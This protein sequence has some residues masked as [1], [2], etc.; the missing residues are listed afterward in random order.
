MVKRASPGVVLGSVEGRPHTNPDS[1]LPPSGPVHPPPSTHD[2]PV[3]ERPRPPSER[4]RRLHLLEHGEDP[5]EER[6]LL[7]PWEQQ[8]EVY[9]HDGGGGQRADRHPRGVQRAAFG[10]FGSRGGQQIAMGGREEEGGLA[11]ARD[12]LGLSERGA[13]V[14]HE[15]GEE[16]LLE[17][18]ELLPLVGRR[19]SGAPQ[20][21]GGRAGG[22][23]PWDPASTPR[24]PV[25]SMELGLEQF[26]PEPEAQGPLA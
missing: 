18:E 9:R 14:A 23:S 12:P 6:R 19:P 2:P 24:V 5:A 16:P 25:L 17:L 26:E 8:A 1:S 13:E 21:V 10:V 11:S 3:S 20:R 22:A 7:R 15:Q 4:S